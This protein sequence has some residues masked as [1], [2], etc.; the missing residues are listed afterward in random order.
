MQLK[1]ADEN[2]DSNSKVLTTA[3]KEVTLHGF[4]SL[5]F[6]FLSTENDDEQISFYTKIG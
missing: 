6:I 5:Y 2:S 3:E 1:V 4:F